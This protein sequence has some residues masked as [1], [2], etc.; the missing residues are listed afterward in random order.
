MTALSVV[1]YLPPFDPAWSTAVP[2]W[3]RRIVEGLPLVPDLPL[4]ADEA[5]RAVRVFNRL[6]LPD[7]HGT[8]R[9]E[10]AGGEWFRSIVRTLFG[11]LDPVTLRRRLSELFL[12][13]PKKNAKTTGAA[14]IMVTALI[15]NRRPQ[16]EA[17]IIAPTKDIADTAFSQALGMIRADPELAKVFHVQTH[18]R[19]ITDRRNH[20]FL[21]VKAADTDAVTGSKPTYALIDEVHVFG[22]NAR[23]RDVFLEIRGGLAV[24]PDG[25][26]VQ[27]T[28][29]S[30][31]PPSGVFKSE[32]ERARAVRDGRQSLPL[33]PVLYELPKAMQSSKR[34]ERPSWC[35]PA[36]FAL[37]N[38]NLGLSS[39]PAFL[40]RQLEAAEAE[41]AEAL[42]LFASQYLNVEIGV[43]LNTEGWSGARF[44]SRGNGGPRTLQELI[45]RCEVLCMGIDGGGADDL[46]GIAVIGREEG[47]KRW[48]GWAHALISPEGFDLRKENQ[49]RYQD[50]INE[51]DLTVLD[52]GEFDPTA[53]QENNHLAYVAD[54]ARQCLDSGKLH[55]VGV[56]AAGLGRTVDALETVGISTAA[57]NLTA[58]GQ[59]IKLMNAAKT[60]ETRLLDGSFRHAG[61]GL[62][63][64]S[65]GNAKVRQ[66]STA[67]MIERSASGLGKIDPLMALFN[68]AHL[69]SLNPEAGGRSF[70]DA[71]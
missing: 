39:D 24:R 6:R 54:V 18:I 61:S 12:L 71:A 64:W 31:S 55:C 25:F 36:T 13:V 23:A 16:A 47:T 67:V 68:A 15:V 5:E 33:L 26:L 66:T 38:P 60:L 3:E 11:A 50:F 46:Y 21:M 49:P 57:E 52:L 10:E 40:V 20:A 41:G 65:V 8:P 17:L 30:K 43:G 29:Q 19:R 35:D 4:Y 56:D 62:L 59:G 58:V 34:G 1:D 9:F 45:D 22:S 32:L 70:W 28:T 63:A 69:M 27:I 44:W 42:A 51:G 48:L 14:A 53:E 7:V 37:V 2:D